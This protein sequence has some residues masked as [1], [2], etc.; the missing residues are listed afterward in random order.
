M[1]DLFNYLYYFRLYRVVVV[2]ANKLISCCHHLFNTLI[3]SISSIADA[4]RNQLLLVTTTASR[5]T[6]HSLSNQRDLMRAV[7]RNC[8]ILID[9]LRCTTVDACLDTLPVALDWLL[10]FDH[11]WCC[12][13]SS[14]DT[15][16]F[17]ATQQRA[18]P[19]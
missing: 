6:P 11:R 1:Q 12:S 10:R 5:L 4:P 2:V 17:W 7:L 13:A 16:L 18:A 8:L 9:E 14:E 3:A 19:Q 15:I